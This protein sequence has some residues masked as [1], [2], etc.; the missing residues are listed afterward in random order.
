[1]VADLLYSSG[2]KELPNSQTEDHVQVLRDYEFPI[3]YACQLNGEDTTN[4]LH[5]TRF[6]KS[7]DHYI[8]RQISSIPGEDF[9]LGLS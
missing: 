2:Y 5:T 1:M 7:L 8:F 6:I 4:S 9:P 3:Q